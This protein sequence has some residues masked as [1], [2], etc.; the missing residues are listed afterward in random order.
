MELYMMKYRLEEKQTKGT[1]WNFD[2]RTK[3]VQ[4]ILKQID[5]MHLA[6]ANNTF[7][8]SVEINIFIDLVKDS[9]DVYWFAYL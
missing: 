5:G 7:G 6:L 3:S 4:N 1:F 9:I 2:G 8:S